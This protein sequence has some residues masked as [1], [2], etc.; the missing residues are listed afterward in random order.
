MNYHNVY[1]LNTGN[2]ETI[3][4]AIEH[5][6]NIRFNAHESMYLGGEYYRAGELGE[7]EFVLRYNFNSFEQEWTEKE[8][9]DMNILL[10]VNV[11]QRSK[12]IEDKVTNVV[13]MLLL[14]QEIL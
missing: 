6:L 11:T 8:F 5:A 12:E 7:E 9:H 14:R 10:Y 13:G 4:I 3:R 2:L 1:G